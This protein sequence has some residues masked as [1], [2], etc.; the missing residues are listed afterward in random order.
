[1]SLNIDGVDYPVIDNF[2]NRVVLGRM[3]DGRFDG[4][5]GAIRTAN[6]RLSYGTD[7][8]PAGIDHFVIHQGLC[9]MR[10][11]GPAGSPTPE[12]VG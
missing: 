8:L 9:P 2:G 12:T 1:V 11:N 7:G 5:E 10:Y 3:R 4:C 6:Y